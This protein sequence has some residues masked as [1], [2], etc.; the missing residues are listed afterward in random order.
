MSSK[1]LG[2]LAPPSGSPYVTMIYQMEALEDEM[3]LKL[4]SMRRSDVL[5]PSDTTTTTN[6]NT[7]TNAN[8][9]MMHSDETSTSSVSSS[10]AH[11]ELAN[12]MRT[13]RRA[14]HTQAVVD[15]LCKIVADLFIAESKLLNPYNY[16]VVPTTTTTS[17]TTTSEKT[18]QQ[19]QHAI[20]QRSIQEFVTSLPSRY[21]FSADTP[22]EVL[23][24]MRLMAAVRND[25]SKAVV[26]IHN[27]SDTNNNTNTNTNY[28]YSNLTV[29]TTTATTF[30]GM[31][32]SNN[33]HSLRLVTISCQDAVGLLEYITRL[34][35]SGGS[36]VLDA[37]VMLSSDGIVL[38]S[39]YFYLFLKFF[40]HL[41]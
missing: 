28:N 11:A 30:G 12:E 23:L 32:G 5:V 14:E 13:R 20:I 35:S 21:V 31:M 8:A 4:A 17:I 19:Q 22:S 6:T 15:D 24:H 33:N 34:L 9:N 40:D 18:H 41:F 3:R 39:Y 10:R 29:K 25:T 27:F 38:V 2:T 36:R 16:G 37:D 7:T 1:E 26:H